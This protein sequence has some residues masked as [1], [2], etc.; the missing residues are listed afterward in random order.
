[1]TYSC[2]TY[3]VKICEMIQKLKAV[4]A[5]YRT[6]GRYNRPLSSTRDSRLYTFVSKENERVFWFLGCS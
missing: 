6:V 3:A 2:Q 5:E 4:C 1:M